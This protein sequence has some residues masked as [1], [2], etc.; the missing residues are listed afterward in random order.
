V[1]TGLERGLFLL[2][3]FFSGGMAGVSVNMAAYIFSE[4]E[5]NNKVVIQHKTAALIF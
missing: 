4:V 1:T 5:I 3:L 2:F